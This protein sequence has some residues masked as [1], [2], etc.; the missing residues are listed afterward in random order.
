MSAPALSVAAEL[1][2][3]AL[4]LALLPPRAALYLAARERLVREA[5]SDLEVRSEVARMPEP[6]ER[7]SFPERPLRI[8]LSCAEASGEIHAVN[9]ARAL[10]AE[11]S[12]S[13]APE[14]VLSG[15]GGPT[16]RSAGVATVGDP[17]SRAAMGFD[18]L[19]GLPFYLR[20]LR[21]TAAHFDSEAP[22]LFLP[23]DSPALHVPIARMARARG[24][25]V[26]HFVTP[27]F[28][29][30]AP[31]RVDAYRRAVD[32]ALA[33]LP[34][35][36]PWFERNGVPCVHVGHP[37]LDALPERSEVD[38]DRHLV[39]VLP[40]SRRHVVRR[41]LPW[42]LRELEAV[43]GDRLRAVVLQEDAESAELASAIVRQREAD[44]WARVEVGGLHQHLARAR[45]A[46]SVS[47]TVLLDLCHHRLPT[48][49]V[50]RLENAWQSW[51]YRR[52]LTVPW[53]ASPN[54]LAGS[55]VLPEFCFH[56]E[57]PRVSE[58][59][60]RCYNDDTWRA[61]CVRG[62][63]RAAAR[64]GPPGATERAARHAL[65]RA[66][67]AVADAPHARPGRDLAPHA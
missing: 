35:E 33:I 57:G 17:V 64:L 27:Q 65:A 26:V 19:S 12:A 22:D 6:F 47:G 55:E 7:G 11:A 8:F 28:W 51:L 29:G 52:F 44:G 16:L 60:S 40:G 9:L 66:L 15:L 18:V 31:W 54:L 14:P 41:N 36:V 45:F 21:D 53:F 43:R 50:Y 25:P 39:A 59:L 37:L 32:L 2:R 42:M 24:I 10:R 30:W 1:G 46:L 67:P 49:V 56:G 48:V 3:A 61:E 58:A 5:R 20:L 38:E 4:D 34:F 62:L 23:V 63:E 13:G